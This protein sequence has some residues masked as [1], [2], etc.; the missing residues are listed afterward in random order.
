MQLPSSRC[1]QRGIFLVRSAQ[2]AACQSIKTEEPN[3]ERRVVDED[4]DPAVLLDGLVDDALA[5]R[6]AG[7]VTWRGRSLQ[8]SN[9]GRVDGRDLLKC[10]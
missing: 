7:D 6:L 5:V 3:L 4:V 8:V 10:S 1:L 2:H 9:R